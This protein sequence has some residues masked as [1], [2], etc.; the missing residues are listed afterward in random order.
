[1]STEGR[2]RPP[3]EFEDDELQALLDENGVTIARH[4]KAMEKIF[5]EGEWVPHEL[6]ARQKEIRKTIC[7]ILLNRLKRKH[8]CI[9][10]LLPMKHGYYTRTPSDKSHMGTQLK[11]KIYC[12]AKLLLEEGNAP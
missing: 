3:E 12:K 4:L 2:E 7:K 5:K 9:E 6:T 11:G 1:M 10:S 8:F